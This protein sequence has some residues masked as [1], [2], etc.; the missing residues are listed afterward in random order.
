M[1]K[2]KW[3]PLFLAALM[4][5]SGCSK[6]EYNVTAHEWVFDV[7]QSQTD[8]TLVFCHPDRQEDYDTAQPLEIKL[9]ADEKILTLVA[10]EQQWKLRYTFYSGHPECTNYTLAG[11]SAEG[12]GLVGSTAYYDGVENDEKYTL[13]LNIGG[14][15]LHFFAE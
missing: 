10:G 3:M 1:K 9:T 5:L 14:Y 7:A 6:T 13:I 11:E 12:M 2:M 8:G 15:A 4:L